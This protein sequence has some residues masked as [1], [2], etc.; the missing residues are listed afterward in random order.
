MADSPYILRSVDEYK[1]R[2]RTVFADALPLHVEIGCGKGRFITALSRRESSVNYIAIEREEV[3]IA[4]AARR[5]MQ[6]EGTAGNLRFVHMDVDLL[7][8]Y[9]GVGEIARLYINFCDPWP[10][11][12]KRARRRLTHENYLEK[13][14][15]LGVPEIFFKTDNRI[16]FEASLAS[17]SAC[18]WRM[19]NISL[20]LHNSA[21]D[22]ENIRTEYEDKFSP[23]GPI[24][25][26][27]A[28]RQDNGLAG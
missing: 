6:E 16:L 18:G 12:K 9:F 21:Y 19:S 28:T 26:L 14:A 8:E 15:A 23:H 1:G 13:Y 27:E 4:A 11:K 25:R 5:A 7:A 22:A 10:R 2:M 24:Y 17:F 3:I 20:D